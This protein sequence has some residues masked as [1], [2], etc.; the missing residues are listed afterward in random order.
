MEETMQKKGPKSEMTLKRTKTTVSIPADLYGLM[1]Q[2]IGSERGAGRMLTAQDIII[3]ALRN[4]L[5]T[6]KKAAA[7]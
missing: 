3:D 6:R 4:Y 5:E 7:A 1:W 2:L